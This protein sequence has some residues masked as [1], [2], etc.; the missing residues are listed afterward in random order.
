MSCRCAELTE[1]R[2]PE[3]DRYADEHLCRVG[4][5]PDGWEVTLECPATGI[6]WVMS[7]PDEHPHG[8]GLTHLRRAGGTGAA[9]GP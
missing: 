6:R 7:W 5:S 9:G 1:L 4:S 8:G 3:A 2:G